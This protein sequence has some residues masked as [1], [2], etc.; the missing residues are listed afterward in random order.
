MLFMELFLADYLFCCCCC[1]ANPFFFFSCYV[2]QRTI[3]K[4]IGFY[5]KVHKFWVRF[6]CSIFVQFDFISFIFGNFSFF[7]LIVRSCEKIFNRKYNHSICIY[8][9]LKNNWHQSILL[10]FHLSYSKLDFLSYIPLWVNWTSVS[11]G[12][13]TYEVLKMIERLYKFHF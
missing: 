2:L 8:D 12:N 1:C 5:F 6:F 7:C 3:P 10:L 13:I 11:F 9:V 4:S